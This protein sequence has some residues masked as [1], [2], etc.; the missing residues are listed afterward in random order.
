MAQIGTF[1]CG[2]GGSFTGTIRTLTLNVEASIQPVEKDHDK[3]PD[4]RVCVG[5]DEV[6][7]A[8]KKVSRGERPYLVLKLDDPSFSAPIYASLTS[9]EG[10]EHRL[11]WSR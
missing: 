3:A 2:E 10:D 8:W 9:G 6:G 11:I 5:G 4:Y 1:I 7:A